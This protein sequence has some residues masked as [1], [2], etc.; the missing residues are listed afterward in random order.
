VTVDLEQPRRRLGVG[1]ALGELGTAEAQALVK[2]EC[3]WLYAGVDSSS[4]RKLDELGKGSVQY[5]P[6][7]LLIPA[8]KPDTASPATHYLGEGERG[9]SPRMNGSCFY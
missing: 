6:G 7:R 1:E 3:V 4:T 8:T 5:R 2:R 9:A